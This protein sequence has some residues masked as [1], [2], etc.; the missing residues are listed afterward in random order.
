[1]DYFE[2]DLSPEEAVKKENPKKWISDKPFNFK[3]KRTKNAF[4]HKDYLSDI[5]KYIFIN[6]IADEFICANPK[7]NSRHVECIW[8]TYNGIDLGVDETFGEFHCLDCGKYTFVD[9]YRD[10][11]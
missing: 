11:S 9:Y 4:T 7:C 3:N 6:K 10:S 1:M 2:H 8:Y 5:S